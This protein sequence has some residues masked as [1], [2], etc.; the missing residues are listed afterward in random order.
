MAIIGQRLHCV[1]F[2]LFPP[3][4]AHAGVYKMTQYRE[5]LICVAI[6]RYILSL[7]KERWLQLL[8]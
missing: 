8:S 6:V 7:L 4:Y 5:L 1:L 3:L 2:S